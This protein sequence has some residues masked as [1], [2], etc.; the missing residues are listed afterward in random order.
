MPSAEAACVQR[1][2]KMSNASNMPSARASAP[3]PTSPDASPWVTGPS[4]TRRTISGTT[5]LAP[6][7][8]AAAASS[9]I[10]WSR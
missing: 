4:T 6:V 1:R 10:I 8:A 7:D 9:Q 5:M 3:R 2:M